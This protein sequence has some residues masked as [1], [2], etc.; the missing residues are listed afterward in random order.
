MKKL[1]LLVAVAFIITACATAWK[2]TSMASYETTGMVLA[3]VMVTG[4]VLCDGGQINESDCEDLK[5][6]YNQARD[7]YITAGDALIAVIEAEDDI[8]RAEGTERYQQALMHLATFMPI[9]L[10]LADNVGIDTGG[11]K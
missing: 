2:P 8:T 1:A 11:V 10:E 7:A 6:T 3:E 4:K 5:N 9:L